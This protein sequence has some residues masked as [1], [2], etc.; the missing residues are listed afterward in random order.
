M[1]EKAFREA[2][3]NNEPAND[4]LLIIKET[5]TATPNVLAAWLEVN[6]YIPPL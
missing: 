4:Q 5:K 3:T 2:Q 6:P 1:R